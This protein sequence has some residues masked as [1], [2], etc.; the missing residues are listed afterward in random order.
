MLVVLLI[1]LVI[2]LALLLVLVASTWKLFTK[3]GQPGW[4][5]LIPVLNTIIMVQIAGKEIWWVLLLFVPVANVVAM[6]IISLA[7][8][9]AYGKDTLWGLGLIFL[10]FIFYPML[11]FG[12]AQYMGSSRVPAQA[13]F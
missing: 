7:F 12:N 6:I 11:A 8:A 9:E 2:S 4:M 10:P 5:S 1:S 3:A 13:S